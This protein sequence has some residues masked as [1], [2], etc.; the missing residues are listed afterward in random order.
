MGARSSGYSAGSGGAIPG[1]SGGARS[2]MGCGGRVGVSEGAPGGDG[3]DLG[4]LA[5]MTPCVRLLDNA[6]GAPWFNA[7]YAR[8]CKES[9]PA[10]QSGALGHGLWRLGLIG[11]RD[12]F[13][14]VVIG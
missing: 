11:K 12:E 7:D 8:H 10:Q 3:G 9:A 14:R 13:F 1:C 6:Q 5:M 2:G 4:A